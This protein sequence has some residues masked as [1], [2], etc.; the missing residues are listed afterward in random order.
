MRNA[1]SSKA[2]LSKSIGMASTM[3][4]DAVM[5]KPAEIPTVTRQNLVIIT[6]KG[7]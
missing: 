1:L 7:Y 4:A 3:D 2:V 6:A 5:A